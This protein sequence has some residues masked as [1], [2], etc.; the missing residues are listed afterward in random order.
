MNLYTKKVILNQ[1]N[2]RKPILFFLELSDL[3]KICVVFVITYFSFAR[4][5]RS[6]G[7]HSTDASLP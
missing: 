5:H 7:I 3:I 4:W 6:A 2:M 1:N